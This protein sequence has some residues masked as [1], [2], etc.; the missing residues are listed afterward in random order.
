EVA[1]PPQLAGLG[2][3]LF[4]RIE[5]R[6]V[7]CG[8]PHDNVRLMENWNS[9]GWGAT[10]RQ[11]RYGDYCSFTILPADDQVYSAEWLADAEISYRWNRY[12]FAVGAENLF[13]RFPD[14][15][16]Y[17]NANGA[18]TAQIN[19]GVSA[20]PINTPFGMNGRYVY[21]RVSY[22]F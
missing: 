19:N 21:T 8:Q 17:R 1:T 3:V 7:E 20:Y 11:S 14:R 12:L 10:L 16:L 22:S 18:L 15:N 13:D 6:R 9:N 2:N 4:D 5:R